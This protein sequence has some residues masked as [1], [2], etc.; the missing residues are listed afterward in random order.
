MT[1]VDPWR[2]SVNQPSNRTREPNAPALIKYSVD[3]SFSKTHFGYVP[4]VAENRWLGRLAR[5]F[6][7]EFPDLKLEGMLQKLRV[8]PLQSGPALHLDDS[9]SIRNIQHF[10]ENIYLQDRARWRAENEDILATCTALNRDFEEYCTDRLGL[11]QPLW[12]RVDPA[13]DGL[14]IAANCWRDKVTRRRLVELLRQGRFTYIHPYLGSFHVWALA[15]LLSRAAGRPLAVLSPPPGLTRRVNDKCWFASLVQRMFGEKFVP[16]SYRV[17]NYS[18]LANVIRT[19]FQGVRHIVIKLPDAAGG[20]GNIVLETAELPQGSIGGLRAYLRQAL[21]PL[22][23]SGAS[24]LLVSTWEDQVTASPSAQ[25]WIPAIESGG[26]PRLD[27]LYNQVINNSRGEFLGSSPASFP[28]QLQDDIARRCLLLCHLLQK[29]G[30]VGRCSF[31]MV[32]T[33]E[34]INSGQLMFIECNGRWGGTSG[35]MH[36]V[37]RLFGPGH[38]PHYVTQ[39]ICQPGLERLTFRDLLKAFDDCLF[40]VKTGR[41]WL[42]LLEASGLYSSCIDLLAFGDD[43]TQANERGRLEAPS[44][45]Q[46]LLK[47]RRTENKSS[48]T[49]ADTPTVSAEVRA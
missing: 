25:I 4:T 49:M 32:V 42:V 29:L 2:Q 34:S 24:A 47:A 10:P 16:R 19:Y 38:R 33:G 14:Q 1:E 27:G 7:R 26:P 8:E 3:K 31:D 20:K 28:L 13:D 18:S 45:I 9:S 21:E 6:Q 35:P 15:A 48:N 43:V 22:H 44:R 5:Q 12:L 37:D 30:Y 46:S 41:G 11:G 39:K 17:F 36:M 40:D 23:F